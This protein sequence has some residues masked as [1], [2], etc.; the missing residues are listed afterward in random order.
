MR[1]RPASLLCAL[2]L[3]LALPLAGCEQVSRFI[4]GEARERFAPGET[5]TPTPILVSPSLQS[6]GAGDAVPDGHLALSLVEVETMR[7]EDTVGRNGSGVVVD[8]DHGLILTSYQ[9]VIPYL[10]DG[11]PAYDRI[12][13]GT[14]RT[15]G[16]APIR[17]FEAALVAADPM[18]GLA[19][20]RVTR[21]VD[22]ESLTEGRFDLPA[23]VAGDAR[24]VN[25]GTAVRLFGYPGPSAEGASTPLA[26]H[27]ATVTGVRGVEGGGARWLKVDARL[28][29]SEAGGAAFDGSGSLVGILEQDVYLPTGGVGQMLPLD[30]GLDLIDQARA[31]EPDVRWVAPMRMTGRLPGSTRPLPD[32]GVWASQPAFAAD[33]LEAPGVRD[34]FDY[35]S[36]FSAGRSTLYYEYVL[37]GVPDGALVEER[38][39]LDDL[40]QDSLSSSYRWSG[41][42]FDMTT[43]SISIPG[44]AGLPSGRWRIE[45]W[46]EDVMRSVSTALVGVEPNQPPELSDFQTGS[47]AS[48]DARPASPASVGDRQFLLFFEFTG[49]EDVDEIQWIVFHN[50]RRL[51]SSPPVRWTHGDAG[52]AWVGYAPP[53]PLTAGRWEM[54]LHMQG[55]VIGVEGVT[56]E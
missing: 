51:Y 8:T 19:V 41:E 44:A 39:Y 3:L 56:L 54:E 42:A 21:D 14:N 33:A 20:L 48:T 4:P 29:Y 2:L 27:T 17:E 15:P 40:L 35:E 10:P 46:V 43:D 53:E 23:A 49:M 12:V 11:S 52:R 13:I 28:P 5:A 34:I 16:A 50:N 37:M 30:L 55:R 38:W 7:G 24:V 6:P 1:T 36:R 31:L 25:A 26:A 22:Q 45:V 32:D 47:T 18:T 9:V